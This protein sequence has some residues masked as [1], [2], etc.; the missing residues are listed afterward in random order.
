M[1]SV[2][3][4]ITGRVQGVAYRMNAREQARSLGLRGWVANTDDGAVRLLASGD[5]D[6]V[7]RLVQWCRQ[8]PP[9]ARVEHVNQGEAAADELSS[10]PQGFEIR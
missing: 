2:L 8:G 6:A 1:V 3:L 7:D 5:S 4:T 10:L 9:A